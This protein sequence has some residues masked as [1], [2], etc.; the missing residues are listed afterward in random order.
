MIFCYHSSYSLVSTLRS[1]KTKTTS[2]VIYRLLQHL[3]GITPSERVKLPPLPPPPPGS[4]C[5]TCETT[6]ESENEDFQPHIGSEHKHIRMREKMEEEKSTTIESRRL[7]LLRRIKQC[8][9][10]KKV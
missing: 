9:Q 4:V 8:D 3:D 10:A 2:G 5:E 7:W 6:D 1:F